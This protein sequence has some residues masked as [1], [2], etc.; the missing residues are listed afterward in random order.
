MFSGYGSTVDVECGSDGCSQDREECQPIPI[1]ATD[2]L[3]TG[4]KCLEF[5]RSQPVPNLN[6]TMGIT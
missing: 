2:Q 6:C 4:K 1:P 3:F 5:V